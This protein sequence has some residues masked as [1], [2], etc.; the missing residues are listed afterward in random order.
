MSAS[1]ER[2]SP[3]P[4]PG[5]APKQRLSYAEV[6]AVTAVC[7]M[8][9]LAVRL[10]NDYKESGCEELKANLNMFE[11]EKA[12]CPPSKTDKAAA[13]EAGKQAVSYTTGCGLTTTY[14]RVEKPRALVSGALSTQYAS[15]VRGESSGK[16]VDSHLLL[17]N[18]AKATE[19]LVTWATKT[20][21]S[22]TQ[23][24]NTGAAASYVAAFDEPTETPDAV[25]MA[26][27]VTL[28]GPTA[29]HAPIPSFDLA[30]VSGQFGQREK[31]RV[32]ERAR[33]ALVEIGERAKASPYPFAQGFQVLRRA[34]KDGILQVTVPPGG[35]SRDN[36]GAWN[37][38]EELA[39]WNAILFLKRAKREEEER[40]KNS[41]RALV[42]VVAGSNLDKWGTL[43]PRQKSVLQKITHRW[44]SWYVY[45]SDSKHPMDPAAVYAATMATNLA[46]KRAVLDAEKL[47]QLPKNH[48]FE[49][50]HDEEPM[51]YQNVMQCFAGEAETSIGGM[52]EPPS[53][54]P[55]FHVVVRVASG[56]REAFVSAGGVGAMYLAGNL[57]AEDAE[58]FPL[59]EH[60]VTDHPVLVVTPPVPR[61]EHFGRSPPSTWSGPSTSTPMYTPAAYYVHEMQGNDPNANSVNEK[62]KRKHLS[63]E[64]GGPVHKKLAEVF[65]GAADQGCAHPTRISSSYAALVPITIELNVE[66]LGADIDTCMR[67]VPISWTTLSTRTKLAVCTNRIGT[68]KKCSVC[69]DLDRSGGLKLAALAISQAISEGKFS[70]AKD[71]LLKV[72]LVYSMTESHMENV[73]VVEQEESEE[74]FQKA[75]GFA[76]DCVIE[77]L[78]VRANGSGISTMSCE[79]LLAGVRSHNAVHA[80]PRILAECAKMHLVLPWSLNRDVVKS[81]IAKMD[82]KF[83]KDRA[84]EKVGQK[85]TNIRLGYLKH[86]AGVLDEEESARKLAKIAGSKD[87]ELDEVLAVLFGSS[88]GAGGSRDSAGF[89]GLGT[90]GAGFASGSGGGSG[91]GSGG[92]DAPGSDAK[93][94][95]KGKGPIVATTPVYGGSSAGSGGGF[96]SGSG[97]GSGGGSGSGS[98]S[99]SGGKDAPG[100]DAKRNEKGKGPIVATTPVYGGSCA[101]SGGGSGSGSGGGSTPVCEEVPR[102][103]PGSE[104]DIIHVENDVQREVYKHL[105]STHNFEALETIETV[106]AL[107]E[108]VQATSDIELDVGDIV[109]AIDRLEKMGALETRDGKV[110]VRNAVAPTDDAV[111]PTDATATIVATTPVYGGSGGGSVGNDTLERIGVT[112]DEEDARAPIIMVDVTSPHHGAEEVIDLT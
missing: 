23:T 34:A 70:D 64:N 37:A 47:Q 93:R 36:V 83:A 84:T 28:G 96:A 24:A 111:E 32:R 66:G 4:T 77:S 94:N 108:K 26:I 79:K 11:K 29:R 89:S 16:V 53:A 13:W 103:S 100:S 95:E 102:T 43:S 68:H 3:C 5:A 52:R 99:G 19:R 33:K 73:M 106:D 91:S 57:G 14:H 45:E 67:L 97:G 107:R 55:I 54:S 59:E 109:S 80:I 105:A 69:K 40:E 56:T 58:K 18:V 48:S 76:A 51:T 98:G 15:V 10:S 8:A 17:Q 27:L 44:S 20:E 12:A 82:L 72:E 60:A 49:V 39:N 1:E 63:S 61:L 81:V 65:A 86:V 90:I 22:K 41:T 92:K 112:A 104:K 110:V 87:A 62:K 78:L 6:V 25:I 50:L 75:V 46:T 2:T 85:S 88:D 74:L 9:Q 101:G 38:L 7:P 71:L 35:L 21:L 42:R 30:T 31:D